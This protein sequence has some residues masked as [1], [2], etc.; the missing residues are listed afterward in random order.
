M[1]VAG[2]WKMFAGPDPEALA[3]RL[4]GLDGVDVVVAPPYTRLAA[5]VE[6]GL[7]TYAQNVHWEAEG[8][9]TGEVSPPLLLALGERGG[10][11]SGGSRDS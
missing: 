5:C 6:A 8:P 9:F 1:I 11:S 4:D 7:V 2:N 10:E 3:E